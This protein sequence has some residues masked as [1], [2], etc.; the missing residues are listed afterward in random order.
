MYIYKK[1]YVYKNCNIIFTTKY[2]SQSNSN[3]NENKTIYKSNKYLNLAI[4]ME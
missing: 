3:S 2:F 1:V 4:G